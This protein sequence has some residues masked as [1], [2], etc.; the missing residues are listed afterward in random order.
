MIL[1]NHYLY[2]WNVLLLIFCYYLGFGWL[3][4][5][6]KFWKEIEKMNGPSLFKRPIIF[7]W[8]FL[9]PLISL[10]GLSYYFF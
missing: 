2:F 10:V 5:A 7:L 4:G 1:M 3:Y 9:G 8:K 6:E